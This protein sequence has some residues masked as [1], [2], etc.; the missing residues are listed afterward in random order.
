MG[1][2]CHAHNHC[3][4]CEQGSSIYFCCVGLKAKLQGT[5]S[6]PSPTTLDSPYCFRITAELQLQQVHAVTD[7]VCA[8]AQPIFCGRT[9]PVAELEQHVGAEL[10]TCTFD[11]LMQSA[12]ESPATAAP[13][14]KGSSS[15]VPPLQPTP[16]TD[17]PL[18]GGGV[19][20]CQQPPTV[21]PCEWCGGAGCRAQAD[22]GMCEICQESLAKMQPGC[23]R[24]P[25]TCKVCGGAGQWTPA[26]QKSFRQYRARMA[27]RTATYQD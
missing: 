21:G 2:G 9:V 18:G 3:K 13:L 25:P 26:Q 4:P 17:V 23:S 19:Q 11:Q 15:T 6:P 24:F 22:C 16:P 20:L 10:S 12:A 8:P 14:Q 5:P 27:V 1:H 7:C